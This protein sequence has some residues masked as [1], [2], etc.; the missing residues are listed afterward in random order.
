MSAQYGSLPFDEAIRFF[1]GKDLVPTDRWADV[2]KAEHDV[3]FM[4]AGAAKADLLADLHGAVLKGVAKGTTLA[5]FRKDFD[6]IVARHGWTGWKGES[7]D[8]GRAWRTRL[9]YDTNLRTSYQA[10]RWAQVQAGKQWRPYL[11]YKHSDL[12]AHPRPLHKSWDG[13]V[14]AVD[15]PWVQTHWPPNGWG[16]KCRMFA[17]SER[18]LRRME[19][20]GPDT[21]PDDGSYDWTDKVTGEMHR[22]PNGIDPGWDYA[23]GASRTD[24][25]RK[26]IERKVAKLPKEIGKSLKAE[27]EQPPPP[28]RFL[29]KDELDLETVKTLG[30]ERLD[31]WLGKSLGSGT[32]AGVL[33]AP[34]EAVAPSAGQI[35]A[36]LFEDL[37]TRQSLGGVRPAT[38]NRS[39]QGLQVLVRAASRFPDGWVSAA[40]SVPLRVQ[41]AKSRG[42]YS[43]KQW[44]SAERRFEAFIRTDASSTAEHEYT[45]HLQRTMPELDAI[46]QAE[47]RRRTAND[48]SE[49]LF[50]WAKSER[51]RPDQYV[52][53]YQGREYEGHNALEVMTMA[54]QGLLGTDKF[55]DEL[56]AKMLIFDREMLKVAL[57]LLFHFRP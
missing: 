19:K 25:M 2:W 27:T 33:D 13:L 38:W 26:E 22:V 47:H 18:D 24:L 3:G 16:C 42:Y 54:F 17:L 53:R 51:G 56:L 44:N 31:Q 35:R 41:M 15:D 36:I 52:H 49:I 29:S 7:S 37:N 14:V 6:T 50:A 55:A 43:W 28:W 45:H 39:G 4:V 48:P 12:S 11:E 9:I 1:R 34:W 21:P 5:E 8:A 23:P 20:S 32:I 30:Q 10:G 57:G 46:F 40:N